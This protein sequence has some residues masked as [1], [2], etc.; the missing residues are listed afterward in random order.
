LSLP[1]LETDKYLY[2]KQLQ[3]QRP[4][5]LVELGWLE[6]EHGAWLALS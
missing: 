6:Q 5:F 3:C 1:N 4:S 2:G